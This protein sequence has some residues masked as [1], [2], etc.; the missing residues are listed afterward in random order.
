MKFHTFR[1][2]MSALVLVFVSIVV[3]ISIYFQHNPFSYIFVERSPFTK[4][5]VNIKTDNKKQPPTGNTSQFTKNNKVHWNY[6]QSVQ[7]VKD[8][9][10]VTT[11]ELYNLLK[12]NGIFV[13]KVKSNSENGIIKKV[14]ND[15]H[16]QVLEINNSNILKCNKKYGTTI[17]APN[18]SVLFIKNGL[19]TSQFD[20]NAQKNNHKLMQS[21]DHWIKSLLPELQNKPQQQNNVAQQNK[22]KQNSNN[23]QSNPNNNHKN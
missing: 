13:L 14:N 1:N 8:K 4:P 10:N 16:L 9:N 5:I 7:F 2:I 6:Q 19:I 18:G 15:N 21:Y 20:P 22:Q 23:Q 11:H 12:N 3:G 17:L